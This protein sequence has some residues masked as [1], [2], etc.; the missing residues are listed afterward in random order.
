MPSLRLKPKVYL[1][2]TLP[3][4]VMERLQKETDLAWNADDRIAGRDEIIAGL[5][6][7]DALICTAAD[8]VG[9]EI[10]DTTKL[11]VIANFGV[12]FNHIDIAAATARKILV[13]NT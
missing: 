6:G 11:K 2:R 8:Q 9:P 3:P 13:T 1:S 12:G 10:M 7:R 4:A 5:C